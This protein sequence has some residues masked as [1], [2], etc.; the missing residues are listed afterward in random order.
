MSAKREK[1]WHPRD[2]APG[3]AFAGGTPAVPANHLSVSLTAYC[4][5][6]NVDE[7]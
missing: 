3:G 1:D 4:L 6:D 5:G 7:C 2:R